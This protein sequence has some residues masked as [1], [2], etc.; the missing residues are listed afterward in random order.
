M[1]TNL[2]WTTTP[3]TIANFSIGNPSTVELTVAD[4]LNT[5]A[6]FTYSKISGDLPPGL[7]LDNNGIISGVPEYSTAS[8]NYFISLQYD[9]I[10]RVRTSDQRVL[11]GKFTIIISNTVNRDFSWI[12]PA[13]N[14][15]TIPNGQFY[16]L[17]VQAETSN[18][19]GITYSFVSGE[20]PPGIQLISH[21]VNKTITQEQY[22][23]SNIL[24]LS[25]L[26]TI[27][28]GDFAFGSKLLPNTRVI[29]INPNTKIVTLSTTS[30]AP[31]EKNE[32]IEFYSPGLLQGVPT[33]L[34][35]LVADGI[36]ARSYRFTIR[37]INS[38]GRIIDRA[39]S[40][41][42][43]NNDP[44]IIQPE[45]TQLGSHYDGTFYSKQLE[46]I[47]L[48][49][50]VQ[51]EWNVTSGKLPPGLSLTSTGTIAGYIEPLVL[52]GN[53][54]P[55]GFDGADYVID[56]VPGSGIIAQ[57]EYDTAPYEFNQLSQSLTYTFTVQAFDGANYDLQTY[58]FN[59]VSRVGMTADS[60]LH[61]D[62]TFLTIDTGNVR[63]PVIRNISTTLPIGRQ[64]SYYA[65][66]VDGYDFSQRDLT[67][68]IVNTVGTYD[69]S[70]Y[71]ILWDDSYN[72]VVDLER[73]APDGVPGGFDEVFASTSNLPGILLDEDTGWIYGKLNVQTTALE[74]YSFGIVVCK[75][76]DDGLEY[77]SVPKYFTLPVIGDPNSIITWTS[78]SN[79]GTIDNGT[80]SELSVKAVSAVGK[81]LVYTLVDKVKTSCR[82]PQGLVLLPSGE[83][84]GRATFE[85]FNIDDY[86]TTFDNNQLTIDR[87]ATFKVKAETVDNTSNVTQTFTL[88]LNVIDKEP[89]ENLYIK[90]MPILPQRQIYTD[91]ISDT[92]IFDPAFIYRPLDPYY[93]I[94]EELKM[95]FLPGLSAS[96]LSLYQESMIRNHFNKTYTFGDVK[97]AYVL[98]DTYNVKYE[99]VYLEVTDLGENINGTGPRLS[100]DLSD[101]I[102]NP[103]IS[104]NG[105]TYNIIYPNSSENMKIRLVNGIGYQDQS[106]LPLWMTSNQPDATT[107]TGFNIPLGYTKAVVIAFATPGNGEKIT[108]R[109][110]Q[111]NID[112]NRIEFVADRYQLDNYY[113]SN[114]VIDQS[115]YIS[116]RETTFDSD[117]N[118]DVGSLV[119]S[120]T[121]GVTVP[122]NEINGRP[123]SYIVDNGGIDS[124]TNFQG[125]ET[126]VF[127]KQEQFSNP[128]SFNGWVDYSS[129][130]I[131]DNIETEVVEGY[132][133]GGYD[134]YTVIP[135]FLEKSQQSVVASTVRATETNVTNTGFGNTYTITVDS[136]SSIVPGSDIVFSGGFSFGNL[137]TGITYQVTSVVDST[138]IT[139]NKPATTQTFVEQV[140]TG[141]GTNIANG[142]DSSPATSNTLVSVNGISLIPLT[143]YVISGTS[144]VF[145]SAPNNG[146]LIIIRIYSTVGGKELFNDSGS[147]TAKIY[148]NFR[149]GVWKINIIGG[150][151]NLT[152][153]QEITVNDR[154]RVLFGKT[155]SGAVL[156]YS[157]ELDAGLTVPYYKTFVVN[158]TIRIR[159]TFNNDT[160]RFFT[161]RD[162]YYEPGTQ[163]KYVKFPQYG[164]FN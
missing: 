117:T 60:T 157:L 144:I 50:N 128:G 18:N 10:V 55:A 14:L 11:D 107:A 87:T 135:G 41:N 91:L 90:A 15:S 22:E 129:S 40:L 51:I 96:E 108:Y 31:V 75:T 61:I 83:I 5:G 100:T 57:E 112:F 63:I 106:S 110:K 66:K 101:I 36:S 160:T 145:N 141:N 95:L 32:I 148:T 54:G 147:L 13:G 97:T 121:Y 161:H 151:V 164:V 81:E 1:A 76:E 140:L 78:P 2:T 126:I 8:N 71:D 39:F 27:S 73:P 99:V 6:T 24:K 104:E 109:I 25:N 150:I 29:A 162:D 119:A 42:I 23:V 137:S 118:S 53:Y 7:S 88:T 113:S 156:S 146:D 30:T 127:T 158:P 139:I 12:T 33:L 98:D 138:H 28:I 103:Y 19:L 72:G 52:T 35:P 142:L 77:C 94:Q 38:L 17:K 65:F 59:V 80:V 105:S 154:V 3:G 124:V 159:T 136:T 67:Y 122:F 20:L 116:N 153:V 62:D 89:Y 132:D 82:L 131:G 86:S 69:G 37:A 115:T 125:G 134:P 49:P 123:I 9:F 163:D 93:G 120:V 56:G 70:P 74:E 43:T 16:S 4:R 26:Q 58:T 92:S 47:Q 102:S 44:P 143:D 114:Y 149:G 133:S 21:Q 46:V 152:C 79:L 84:S 155:L 34:E 45:T 48:N 85:A 111:T 64:D 68:K 130:F